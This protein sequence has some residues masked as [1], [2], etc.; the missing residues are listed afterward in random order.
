MKPIVRATSYAML[1]VGAAAMTPAAMPAA[2]PAAKAAAPFPFRPSGRID[3]ARVNVLAGADADRIGEF[4]MASN[5]SHVKT[6][7]IGWQDRRQALSWTI[8]VPQAGDYAV[9]AL[10]SVDAKVPVTMTLSTDGAT[11]SSPFRADARGFPEP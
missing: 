4:M 2:A 8:T 7:V 6:E 9:T 5:V 3:P 11:T 1:T 10:L